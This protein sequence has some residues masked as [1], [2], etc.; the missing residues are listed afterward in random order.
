MPGNRFPTRGVLKQFLT[1]D[2]RLS[3]LLTEVQGEITL[4]GKEDL[5]ESRQSQR[6][7]AHAR[8]AQADEFLRTLGR[9][10][11]WIEL[12]GISGST[13]YTGAKAED[14]LDFFLVAE[15]RRLWISLLLAMATAR[16]LR[17]RSSSSPVYCFNR[18]VERAD[19]EQTFRTTREPLFAREALNLVILRGSRLYSHLLASARWMETVFPELYAMRLRE[20]GAA[21]EA[22]MGRSPAAGTVANAAAFLVLGPYLWLAGI[23]RNAGLRRARRDKECFRTVI[24]PDRYATESILYD[25]LREGYRKA[26][27]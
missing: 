3:R 11:P 17:L 16:L 22:T 23:V 14:D 21:D 6:I 2:D 20:A 4:R 25:E 8:L 10:C 5:A 9:F 24:R 12:A 19:C 13:A 18:I 15:R 27:E 26:F 7:L 1:T